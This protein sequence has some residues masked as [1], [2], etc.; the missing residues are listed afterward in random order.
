VNRLTFAL[1]H[2]GLSVLL[3]LKAMVAPVAFGACAILDDSHGRILL[4]RH[5]YRPG[6]YLPG[7]GVKAS[8]PPSAGIIRELQEEIG[9]V[10]GS[11]P[12]LAGLFTRRL[13]W[14]SNVVALYRIRD[15]EIA[16]QPNLEIREILFAD[17]AAPPPGT[18]SGTRRR[19][20]EHLGLTAQSP[21][22]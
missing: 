1:S 2:A 9:F 6:W 10:R 14:V 4:V 17:P 8:E 18:T 12:E 13:G 22:W 20:A 3:G 16:F 11:A 21:Y 19:L 15:A 7:G 5:S